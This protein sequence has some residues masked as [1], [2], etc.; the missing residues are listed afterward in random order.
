MKG[1]VC[2]VLKFAFPPL[3]PPLPSVVQISKQN[4]HA[5]KLSYQNIFCQCT[6]GVHWKNG[7]EQANLLLQERQTGRQTDLCYLGPLKVKPEGQR[8]TVGVVSKK[9]SSAD[10][11]V[12]QE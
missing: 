7:R 8:P 12:D 2:F 6:C 1:S 9:Y 4:M 3:S 10:H 5:Q 11:N